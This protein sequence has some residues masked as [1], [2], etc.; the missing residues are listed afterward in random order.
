MRICY[1]NFLEQALDLEMTNLEVNSTV[2]N[3]YHPY[4][5]LTADCT[6]PDATLTG[7]FVDG[8]HVNAIC[9]GFHNASFCTVRLYDVDDALIVEE[10]VTLEAA[11]SIYY[12]FDAQGVYRFE[13]D[14]SAG[15]RLYVGYVFIGQYLELPR[16]TVKAKFDFEL[17]STASQ[18][19]G[20]QR[21]GVFRRWLRGLDVTF[22]RLSNAE[23]MAL[24]S[25]ASTVQTVKPHMIDPF[26]LAHGEE[27][28]MYCCIDDDVDIE[29]RDE[30]GFFYEVSL[31][32]KEAR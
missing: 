24:L 23:R 21:F 4:M 2:R 8:I 27:P 12:P 7:R 31:K 28:P 5:E 3:L 16:F 30:S 10:E 20:G 9:V 18:S 14:F 1:E 11:D 19:M 17:R 15:E 26:P 29:K 22:P 25:Y 13:M 6:E 32:W